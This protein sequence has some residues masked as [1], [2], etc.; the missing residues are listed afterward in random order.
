MFI[1][2]S[3]WVHVHENVYERE[4]VWIIFLFLMFYFLLL[5][6]NSIAFV[7]LFFLRNKDNQESRR[8][9]S[10]LFKWCWNRIL[11]EQVFSELPDCFL[12]LDRYCRSPSIHISVFSFLF[13]LVL[14]HIEKTNEHDN[15]AIL[16]SNRK[17]YT[18]CSFTNGLGERKR[19]DLPS[20]ISIGEMIDTVYYKKTIV[21]TIANK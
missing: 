8:L 19:T 9:K 13:L 7:F 3:S 16:L 6:F 11:I 2:L 4:Q 12:S 1:C 17:I 21:Q 18:W 10:V 15:V 20:D 5:L 14:S